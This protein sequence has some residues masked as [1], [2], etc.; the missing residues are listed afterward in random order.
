M[1]SRAGQVRGLSLWRCPE[2]TGLSGHGTTLMEDPTSAGRTPGWW[3]GSCATW[4]VGTTLAGAVGF[5]S[6]APNHGLAA[7]DDVDRWD[8]GMRR[9]SSRTGAGHA[10]VYHPP[11][12]AVQEPC[13]RVAGHRWRS[14]VRADFSAVRFEPGCW[15]SFL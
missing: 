2:D 4:S 5:G 6:C 13:S 1:P 11:L 9:A 3:G 10:A 12:C 14:G 7:R 15:E 8:G